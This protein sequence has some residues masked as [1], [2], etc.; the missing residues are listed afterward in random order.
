MAVFT[1]ILR[2]MTERH[3]EHYILQFETTIDLND[4]LMEILMVIEDLVRRNVYQADWNEMIM[5][6]N[7][8][9]IIIWNSVL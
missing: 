4:F 7:W 1:S 5:L 8:F 6:Q 9:V 2:Q 3:Y